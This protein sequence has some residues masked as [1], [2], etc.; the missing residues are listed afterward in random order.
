MLDRGGVLAIHC[1]G[2]SGR[3]GLIAARILM[4]R[5]VEREAAVAAVQALRPN[6]I[7]HPVHRDWIELLPD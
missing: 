3:T 4:A 7:S 2:G 5:G 6:A 1:K